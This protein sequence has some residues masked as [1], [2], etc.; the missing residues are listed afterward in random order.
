MARTVATI[1]QGTLSNI[2]QSPIQANR[3]DRPKYPDRSDKPIGITY[4][5]GKIIPAAMMYFAAA[6]KI[7]SFVGIVDQFTWP[8]KS[9]TIHA[10]I[11]PKRFCSD[12]ASRC[13]RRMI[14]AR[15]GWAV[16]LSPFSSSRFADATDAKSFDAVHS[17]K[18][19]SCRDATF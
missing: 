18:E 10:G 16:R 3:S 13:G 19:Q 14:V 15:R 4:A 8:M 1:S 11:F 7:F 9:R 6:T 12:W 5:T 2:A 17:R